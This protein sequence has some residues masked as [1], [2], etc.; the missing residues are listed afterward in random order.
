MDPTNSMNSINSPTHSGFSSPIPGN[1]N[2]NNNL[3]IFGS[4]LLTGS[5]GN[6]RVSTP[7]SGIRSVDGK[8]ALQRMANRLGIAS[9]LFSTGN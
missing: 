5:A 8:E 2:N 3:N 6:S 4:A 7:S 1:N 9:R